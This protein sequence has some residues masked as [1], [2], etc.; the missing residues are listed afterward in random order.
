MNIDTTMYISNKSQTIFNFF[1][2][3]SSVETV[4]H[5]FGY[6]TP[7]SEMMDIII[8]LYHNTV[9]TLG[10]VF[11]IVLA[12]IILT[13]YYFNSKVNYYTK[14]F[15]RR[16]EYL[17]DSLFVFVPI[18]IIYCLSVP[19]IGY[20]MSNDLN[21]QSVDSPFNIEIIGHQWYWTYYIN[22]NLGGDVYNYIITFLEKELSS[23]FINLKIELEQIMTFDENP[24]KRYFEVG[25]YVIL[26]VGETIRCELTSV[27]VIHSWAVPQL[28]IKIDAIPGR[29]QTFYI[30]SYI[31]GVVYGQCSEF[32]GENHGFMPIIIEF[33][34]IETFFDWILKSFEIN[35]YQNFLFMI[36]SHEVILSEEPVDVLLKHLEEYALSQRKE[37]ESFGDYLERKIPSWTLRY[38]HIFVDLY[39]PIRS[40][41]FY[42]FF[43]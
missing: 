25:K 14:G 16:V 4:N 13:I 21:I 17:I 18:I 41:L 10:Y 24:T 42:Y 8:E 5:I 26:P 15:N 23:H 31:T 39:I 40:L 36:L 19:A 43:R 7:A 34:E 9:I 38:G 29:V 28:G 27:D 11:Y 22:A 35:P 12:I 3:F 30:R 20:I 33:V 6:S 2:L 1:N 32:C 37:P